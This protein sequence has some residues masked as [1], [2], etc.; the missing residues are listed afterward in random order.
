MQQSNPGPESSQR[1]ND[2]AS[3]SKGAFAQ[4]EEMLDDYMVKKAP[5]HIPA[6]GKEFIVKISPYLVIIGAAMFLPVLFGALGLTAVLSPYAMMGGYMMGGYW[7][8]YA[9][10]ALVTGLA[11]FALEVMAVPGLFRRTRSSWRL[12]Y[13]ATFVSLAGSVLSGSVVGGII[14]AIIGWYILFQVKELYKN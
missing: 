11:V 1:H 6:N 8:W 13:Y 12:V 7:G 5:F 14:G 2:S 9:K 4:F 10:V 3:S